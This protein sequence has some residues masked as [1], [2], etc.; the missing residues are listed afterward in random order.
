MYIYAVYFIAHSVYRC[1]SNPFVLIVTFLSGFLIFRYTAVI[2]ICVHDLFTIARCFFFVQYYG[3]CLSEI[4]SQQTDY[5]AVVFGVCVTIPMSPV[6][7]VFISVCNAVLSVSRHFVIF[8]YT[9]EYVAYIST[10]HS[11]KY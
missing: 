8:L 11:F 6:L 9:W 2:F 3:V 1:L 5:S 7:I 4:L 10:S